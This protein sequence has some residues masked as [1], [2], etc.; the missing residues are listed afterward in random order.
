MDGRLAARSR[1]AAAGYRTSEWHGRASPTRS[2]SR[3]RASTGAYVQRVDRV[4]VSRVARLLSDEEFSEYI[5]AL[6][7]AA[8]ATSESHHPAEFDLGFASASVYPKGE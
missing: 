6:E 8:A 1:P 4:T 3:R 2:R 7:Q 5:S